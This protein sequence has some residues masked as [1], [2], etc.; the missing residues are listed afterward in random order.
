MAAPFIYQRKVAFGECDPARIFF[1]PRAVDYAVEAVEAWF[2]E[3]LGATWGELIR[4]HNLE[5]RFVSVECDYQRSLV[6]GQGIQ[7]R[8]AAV[9]ADPDAFI[10]S[11]TGELGAAEPSFSAT[12][13]IRF[14]DCDSGRFIPAPERFLDIARSYIA[15]CK[16]A[17]PAIDDAKR[18]A[19]TPTQARGG[20]E[21]LTPL[22]LSS[23]AIFM[24]QR[25]VRYG[26]C[27][28]SGDIYLPKLVEW[29]V[30]TVGEWYESCLGVS[31]LE[32]CI[33]K[34]GAPFLNIRCEYLR[35]L[36]PG[37]TITMAVRIPRLGNSSIGYE[38]IGYDESGA[39]CLK[40]QMAACYISEESGSP[41]PI[42]FPDDMRSRILTYQE[43]CQGDK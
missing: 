15:Q 30:E 23:A 1:S 31:W 11:A 13:E 24:R 41:R 14:V 26:E 8:L 37:Q 4:S 19:A 18:A 5:V 28:I 20:D 25:R 7:V 21:E 39:P 42:P 34:R 35:P 10:L 32:Q 33:R 9:K 16:D 17:I 3:V 40:S 6:A 27:G 36:A 2:E 22:S 29:A 43:A 12:L 38:V